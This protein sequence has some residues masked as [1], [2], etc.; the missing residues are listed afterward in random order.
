MDEISVLKMLDLG[1]PTAK[2]LGKT[3]D[4]WVS[5]ILKADSETDPDVR[6]SKLERARVIMKNIVRTRL[7]DGYSITSYNANSEVVDGKKLMDYQYPE[8]SRDP[9]YK[10]LGELKTLSLGK[11]S[12]VQIANRANVLMR[13]LESR[14]LK[15]EVY[16][17]INSKTL[18]ELLQSWSSDFEPREGLNDDIP[19]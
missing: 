8:N 7:S 6:R 15:H 19:L 9:V 16:E 1:I 11:P 4:S 10:K 2:R 3:H 14:M 5:Y 18:G 17:D 12:H 13:G